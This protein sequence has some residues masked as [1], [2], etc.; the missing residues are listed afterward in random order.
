MRLR[1]GKFRSIARASVASAI[2]VIDGGTDF[3]SDDEF[4]DLINFAISHCGIRVEALARDIG[5]SRAT[6]S[7]WRHDIFPQPA[8]RLDIAKRIKAIL[9]V[10]VVGDDKVFPD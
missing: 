9:I 8:Y 2:A 7:R 6:V 5:V 3:S 10:E 4:R 1:T